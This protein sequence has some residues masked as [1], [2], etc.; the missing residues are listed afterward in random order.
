MCNESSDWLQSRKY[1]PLLLDIFK[2]HHKGG[3]MGSH[4]VKPLIQ[5]PHRFGDLAKA[6]HL[7]NH[8]KHQI[9]TTEWEMM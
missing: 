6:F 1:V 8:T 9:I 2:T 3:H 5:A 4:G 7:I